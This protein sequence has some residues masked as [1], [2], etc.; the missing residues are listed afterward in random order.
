MK[1]VTLAIDDATLDRARAYATKRGT[2]LNA[3]VRQHLEQLGRNEEHLDQA[4][5]ELRALSET[6]TAR[7]GPDY[8]FDREY[9][10]A[11]RVLHRHQRPDLRGDGET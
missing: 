4:M 3:L 1:N 6:T 9:A 11:E 2:T 5:R 8:R 10:Y 7:L